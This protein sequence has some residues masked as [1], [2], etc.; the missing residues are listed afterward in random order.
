[1]PKMIPK[2]IDP[3]TPSPGEIE[4]F[5]RISLEENIS[6]WTI[7]HS[8][9]IA[10][11]HHQTR[12][13]GEIDFLVI[14]P[15]LGMIAIEIKAHR[16][17][18]I[19][20]G[21]WFLGRSDQSGSRNP[22]VQLKDTMFSLQKYI[23]NNNVL[24]KEIPI[25]PLV[26]F[27]HCEVTLESVE[28][29]RTS[30]ASSK[31][32]R[33]GQLS[34][35]LKKK[36]SLAREELLKKNSAQWLRYNPDRPD[37]KD[38]SNLIK[39]LRPN[40]ELSH[41]VA[42]HSETIEKELLKFTAEQFDALDSLADHS[43]VLFSGPAGTGKTFI[44]IESA[45]RAAKEGSKVLFICM[46]KLLSEHLKK[47]LNGYANITV[48]TLHALL[49]SYDPK[50][51]PSIEDQ[52]NYWN[53]ELP[54]LAYSN[55][56]NKSEDGSYDLLIIDEA[57]DIIGNNL[58]LDCLDL[59]LDK[60][61]TYGKWHIFGDFVYQSIYS[62]NVSES[63]LIDNLRKRNPS[64]INYKLYKNCRNTESSSRRSLNLLAMDSP[65]KSYL[66]SQSSILDSQ[67][68][69]YSN[70][71]EQLKK[72]NEILKTCLKEGFNYS[73]IVIL[74]KVAESK[75]LAHKNKELL[76]AKVYTLDPDGLSYTSIH[77]FKGLEAPVIILIDFDEIESEE[78]QKMMFTGAT[79]ATDSVHFLFHKKIE[80][81]F[82]TRF[83]KALNK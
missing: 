77:K 41:Q 65:Y 22:F 2:R 12:I 37:E 26:I 48:S 15:K 43:C 56:I 39:L 81:T 70:D 49:K 72:L 8:L 78:A 69:M 71:S 33:S 34:E 61:L 4:F 32:F 73:D 5:T 44:A 74:S 18:R 16:E 28:V 80:K 67:Y 83:K 60:G 64:F 38:I 35:L 6:D 30:Y 13:M 20:D 14:I 59:L 54:Q 63:E 25:F 42:N 50:T 55:I 29:D 82:Q 62:K 11:T 10:P 7:L 57:Q 21:I 52:Y 31:E 58:W 53:N 36:I 19:E 40:L 23:S 51:S 17:I 1:M 45:I 76:N 46:N 79:R 9:N 24:L 47:Q 75:S 27:T 68:Y 66:R 3:N